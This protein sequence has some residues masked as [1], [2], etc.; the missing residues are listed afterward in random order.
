MTEFLGMKA[1]QVMDLISAVYGESM[2][3]RFRVAF[4]IL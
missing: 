3:Q 1:K 4:S 2:S